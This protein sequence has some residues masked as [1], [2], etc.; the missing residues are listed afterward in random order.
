[1]G[2]KWLPDRPGTE[3]WGFR[4]EPLTVP[5]EALVVV[6][7]VMAEQEAEREASIERC[8]EAC[9]GGCPS[10]PGLDL[11]PETCDLPVGHTEPHH[12]PVGDIW[13]TGPEKASDLVDLLAELGIE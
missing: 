10:N 7:A 5:H 6:Q 4:G 13:E 12:C 2:V 1:M 9:D 3:R 11:Y 8:G